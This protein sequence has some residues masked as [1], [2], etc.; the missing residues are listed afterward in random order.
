MKATMADHEVAKGH[1]KETFKGEIASGTE[2]SL[3]RQKR[4]VLGGELSLRTGST[5]I[6][7][8]DNYNKD[9]HSI[10]FPPCSYYDNIEDSP[11]LLKWLR[12]QKKKK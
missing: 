5:Y 11:D 4:V 6:I 12:S 3:V 7:A 8:T 1:V 10:N 2:V 9:S